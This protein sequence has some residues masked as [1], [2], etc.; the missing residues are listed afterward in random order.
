M[1]KELYTLANSLNKLGLKK[2]SKQIYDILKYAA[3]IEEVSFS[4]RGG[5]I[6]N[7]LI[8]Q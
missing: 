2:E 5:E 8:R 6:E 1:K 7:K 3:P 4:G